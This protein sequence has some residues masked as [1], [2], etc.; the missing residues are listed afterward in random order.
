MHWSL[1]VSEM[2][3]FQ[4]VKYNQGQI[5]NFT[6][7][8]GKGGESKVRKQATPEIKKIEIAKQDIYCTFNFS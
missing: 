5:Q 1:W 6:K 8:W 3:P 2:G 7:Q 4:S